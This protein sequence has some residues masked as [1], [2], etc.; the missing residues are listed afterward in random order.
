M[1]QEELSG[2]FEFMDSL[3]DDP[4]WAQMY[5]QPCSD[6]PWPGL[7]CE[8]GQQTPQTFHVTKIHI[9]P[10]VIKPPCKSSANLSLSLLNLPYLKTLSLFNC[11]TS[12]PLSLSPSLF[13]PFS[14][15]EHLSLQSNPSLSGEIP[16]T[17]AEIKSLRVLTLSQNN[18]QGEIPKNTFGGL[19]HLEQ[20]DLSSNNLIGSIPEE[21]GFLKSLKILDLSW[22]GL[23]GQIP[24]SLGQLQLLQKIDLRSNKLQG[25]VPPNLGKLSR[26]VLLDLSHNLLTG[27]ISEALSGLGQLEYFMIQENPINS[28]IPRFLE[29]LNRLVVLSFSGCGLRGKLSNTL[30]SLKNLTAL[31]LDNNVLNGTIPP[32]LGTLANLDQLNLSHN[33]FSGEL[34]FSEEFIVRLGK[35]LDVRGNSGVCLNQEAYK[36]KKDISTYLEI[37]PCL[38]TSAINN[39]SGTWS[40]EHNPGDCNSLTPFWDHDRKSSSTLVRLEDHQKLG[41]LFFVVGFINLFLSL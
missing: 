3:L 6:T 29:S 1:E 41:L 12:S 20:L 15:L 22:N 11:F 38:G 16:Q 24:S 5:P 32:N 27:P 26:L 4:T 35:R 10:D 37:A 30:S 2:L 7:Q 19:V 21:I 23:N 18:L 33:Q 36:D 31:S 40:K 8:V 13:G 34:K 14:L 9:G 28:E 25:L 17:L 39:N